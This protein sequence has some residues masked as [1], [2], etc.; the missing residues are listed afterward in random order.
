MD[1]YLQG[2]VPTIGNE[3]IVNGSFTADPV[4]GWAAYNETSEDWQIANGYAYIPEGTASNQTFRQPINPA[5]GLPY[6]LTLKHIHA[7][8]TLNLGLGGTYSRNLSPAGSTG[9]PAS[10]AV[11]M[12]SGGSGI[13]LIFQATRP[14]EYLSDI[15]LRE[16]R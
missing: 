13:N 15:S 4:S 8:N 14:V 5:E 7:L 12:I 6:I 9:S 16:I 3:L 2:A 10:V 1:D 11:P